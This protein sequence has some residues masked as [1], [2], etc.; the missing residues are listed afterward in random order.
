MAEWARLDLSAL[1]PGDSVT[2]ANSGNFFDL[3]YPKTA[4]FW[5]AAAVAGGGIGIRPRTTGAADGAKNLAGH[6]AEGRF[7]CKI[8][9]ISVG[10]ATGNI[11]MMM[12]RTGNVS[13]GTILADVGLRNA[14]G[15]REMAFRENFLYGTPP[16]QA[17]GNPMLAN[18][19]WS[20][21]VYWNGT[22]ATCYVWDSP[23]TSGAPTYTWAATMA[24]TPGNMLFGPD[25]ADSVDAIIYDV[26]LTDGE[27]LTPTPI[28]GT[29]TSLSNVWG[30]Q[31]LLRVAGKVSGATK[32]TFRV[33]SNSVDVA[34]DPS[35]YFRAGLSGLTAGV[36]QD[37]EVLVDDVSRRTGST[38]TLPSLIDGHVILWGSCFDTFTSGF[39]ANAAARNPDIIVMEGDWSYPYLNGVIAS[40]DVATVRAV[41]E[42][43]LAA[44]APQAL[45]TKYITSY[46]YSDTDGAGANSDSTWQGFTSGAVQAAY[47]QQWAHPDFP[48]A[49]CGARSWVIE[50]VRFIHTD[51][52][53]LASPQGAAQNTPGKSKLGV[54][55]KAWF[56]A[57]LAAADEAGQSVVWFGDGPWIIPAALGGN[58]WAAYDAERTELGAIIAGYRAQGM[59]FVRLHG[60]THTLFVDDGTNNQWGGFLTASAAPF[61]TTANT[62]G[63]PVTGGEGPAIPGHA[64]KWPTAQT[65][66]SRQYGVARFS[67]S[68]GLVTLNLRG[69]SSTNSEPTEVERFSINVDMTPASGSSQL[70]KAVYVGKNVA[71][72]TGLYIGARKVWP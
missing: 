66:S 24:N 52:I 8:Q 26:W 10:A 34:P 6:S 72:A 23:V 64:P 31:S 16:R 19:Q 61:H 63:G 67:K 4:N 71:Q 58:T 30:N 40:T 46:T 45:F 59:K 25:S 51:E 44:A 43:V 36:S 15:V 65:N 12:L 49:D 21:E 62:Y 55:Q 17:T 69:Y 47:R 27:R 5:V 35:G 9:F 53:T 50:G 28:P 7:G 68:A 41:K 1:S 29:L 38:R 39:F 33:G 54:S 60:D 32:V 14:S 13:G 48:L 57:E 2:A 56:L 18:E 70:F 42:P 11:E 20:V 3:G 22:A 37:W